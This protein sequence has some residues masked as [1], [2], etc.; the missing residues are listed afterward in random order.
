MQEINRFE[1]AFK[2]PK[3]KQMFED[4]AKEI[5]DP[6]AR[7]ESEAYLRQ[8][9]SNNEAQAHYGADVQL[10]VPDEA[11]VFKTRQVGGEGA[12]GSGE[13]EKV[14]VNVCTCEKIQKA[15]SKKK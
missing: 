13:G 14:F 9:E 11:W 5:S 12:D 10:I 15:E 7:A 3:F 8:I 6:K 1:K 4:Y 2:D